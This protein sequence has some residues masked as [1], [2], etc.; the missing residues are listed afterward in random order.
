MIMDE[1]GTNL[2]PIMSD[3]MSDQMKVHALT[4]SPDGN[5]IIFSAGEKCKDL[6]K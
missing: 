5:M 1:N 3:Q 2:H 4:W 6:Y